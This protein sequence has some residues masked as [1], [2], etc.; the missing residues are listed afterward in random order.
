M[1]DCQNAEIRDQLPDLL[2]DRLTAGERA[3]VLAHVDGCAECRGELELL[4]GVH[5]VLVAATP[6]V[7]T[8][9]ILSALPKPGEGVV[10]PMI[11]SRA[12]R[13]R[14]AD[15]RIAAAVTVIAV[16]GG[17]FALLS[18]A[19]P[20]V[21]VPQVAAVPVSAPARADTQL[22][23]APVVAPAPNKEV[24][25]VDPATDAHE[26]EYSADDDASDTGIEGRIDNLSEQQLKALLNDIGQM[27]AVPVT[28]PDPITIKV[29]SK[30]SSGTSGATEIM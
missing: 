14:W 23:S 22:A 29:D 5:H 2:H 15:W 4:R 7:N 24:A 3:V 6:R 10:V 1:N 28:E 16:G 21:S 13:S 8:L 26:A 11:Q 18:R 20:T 25:Q 19:H 12:T 30:A 27:K 9:R 17:S